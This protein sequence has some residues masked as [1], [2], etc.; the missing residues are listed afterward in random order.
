MLELKNEVMIVDR[1]EEALEAPLPLVTSA[2]I[3]TVPMKRCFTAWVWEILTCAL[4]IGTNFQSS[5]EITSL[6]KEAGSQVR[7]PAR[8]PGISRQNSF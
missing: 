7:G 6:L 5:L 4:C 8:P 3:G 2:K 1:R